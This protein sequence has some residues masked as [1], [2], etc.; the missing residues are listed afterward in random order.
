MVILSFVLAILFIV[1]LVMFWFAVFGWH[2]GSVSFLDDDLVDLVD[3][4]FLFG[5]LFSV[6]FFSGFVYGCLVV[7]DFV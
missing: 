6:R 4:V 5:F 7:I 3:L 2:V 1:C